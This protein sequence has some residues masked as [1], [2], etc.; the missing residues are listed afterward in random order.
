MYDCLF[1][2]SVMRRGVRLTWCP[3]PAI[4]DGLVALFHLLFRGDF[5]FRKRW[6]VDA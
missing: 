4:C 5:V 6:S 1:H 3:P 2:A